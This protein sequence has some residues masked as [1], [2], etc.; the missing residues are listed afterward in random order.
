M[1]CP[2][3]GQQQISDEVRFCP[4]CGLSLAQVPALLTV[5]DAAAA[6]GSSPGVPLRKRAQIRRGAKI[7]FFSA[8]LFPIFLGLSIAVD[9]PGPLIVPFTVFL[10][11]LAW[12]LYFV[13]FGEEIPRAGAGEGRKEFRDSHTAPALPPSTF[14]PA[15]G[16]GQRRANTSDMA[17]QPPSVTEQTTRLLDEE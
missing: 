11:G 8:V 3:C 16:F 6:E 15:S 5:G 1:F 9:E 10:A 7:M 2:R 17:Q 14:V 12:M 13:L 4:R